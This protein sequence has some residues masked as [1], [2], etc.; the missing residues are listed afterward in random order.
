MVKAMSSSGNGRVLGGRRSGFTLVELLMVI[1]IIAV[2][3][4]LVV[5]LIARVKAQA[6]RALCMSNQKQLLEGML[7]YANQNRGFLPHCNKQGLEMLALV[8]GWLYDPQVSADHNPLSAQ[9][10][11]SGA[12]WKQLQ[13]DAV[14]R[15][16]AD[17]GP[18]DRPGERVRTVTNYL[19]NES[20][21]NFGKR[22]GT[23]PYFFR[24]TQFKPDDIIVWEVGE[25][26]E[27]EN[28]YTDGAV[29]P[30][31]GIARRHG[32]GRG[33][34]TGDATNGGM[35]GTAGLAVEW[36]SVRDFNDEVTPKPP[37]DPGQRTR[38]WNVPISKNGH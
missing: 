9:D 38:V 14:F 13:N 31:H 3:I 36:M 8:P 2:L 21:N 4:G 32:G 37:R 6:K 18:L 22:N 7:A 11:H 23:L 1:A 35:V 16:P 24:L 27:G 34:A 10:L 17:D 28:S 15:C 25:L 29:H 26:T 12:V 19:M 5:P 33:G 30:A 20:V